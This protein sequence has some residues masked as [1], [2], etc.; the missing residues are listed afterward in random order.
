VSTGL[1]ASPND[2]AVC[3][4]YRDLPDGTACQGGAC[5]S[6]ACAAAAPDAGG[7]SGGAGGCA[8]TPGSRHG[9]GVQLLLALGFLAALVVRRRQ[10]TGAV[11]PPG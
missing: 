3:T 6:G 9:D 4:G 11:A 2:P 1:C 8:L 5:R 10:A 7:G